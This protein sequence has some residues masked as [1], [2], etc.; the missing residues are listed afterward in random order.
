MA[1]SKNKPTDIT[2][3]GPQSFRDLQV[4]NNASQG[5][6]PAVYNALMKLAPIAGQNDLRLNSPRN[7]QSPVYN[8]E[9][10]DFLGNSQYD[11][12]YYTEDE[13]YRMRENPNEL[14][15]ENQ[16]WYDTLANGIGKM[17]GTAGTTFVSSLV[18]LPYGLFQVGS[19]G[20]W[21]AIW[22]NDVTQGLAN[23]DKWLE[24]N[25]TNYKSQKQIDSPWYDPANLFSMNF[26][27]D[28]I[29]KN[30]G[31]TLGAAASMAVGS[32]SLGLMS[33]AMGL[34]GGAGSSTKMAGN[35]LSALFSATGEGMIEARQGV[36]E[37]NKLELQRLDD[38]MLP[39]RQSLEAEFNKIQAEY[40]ANKGLSYVRGSDGKMQDAAYLNYRQRMSDLE[41]RRD[42]F[43][44]RYEAGK[45][46]IEETGLEMGNM[47]LGANQILL[48]AGN[49]IQ[50]SKIMTKSFDNARHAAENKARFH[51]P[52]GV[53]AERAGSTFREGY[54]VTGKNLGMTVAATKGLL[55]EG[56][57][58][59]NQQ[60]IQNAAGYAT[61]REDVNDYWR[62]KLDPEAT[63]DAVE[64]TYTLGQA[65][66]RGFNES[67]SDIDQ[68]EQFLI[69]GLTGLAG[70]YAPTK[71][72]NQDKTKAWYDL[73]RYGEWGGGAYNEIRDFL[74]GDESTGQM[75]Y[76]EYVNRI[77]EVNNILG[78][79]DFPARVSSL[80]GHTFLESQKTQSAD[81]ND[82]KS[83]KDA[84]DKQTIMDIQAFLRAGKL[85]DLRAIYNEMGSNLSDEDID[86]IVKSTTH[87]SSKEENKKYFDS[88]IDSRI[89][90]HQS[91]I[92]RI[93]GQLSEMAQEEEGMDAAS[94]AA[95]RERNMAQTA[96]LTRELQKEQSAIE[97][98]NDRKAMYQGHKTFDGPY[99]DLN[100]NRRKSNDEIREEIK[101]NADEL[102]RRIDS[103]LD[104]IHTVQE[105]SNGALT[106][107]QEDNL[108]YLHNVSKE[109][110]SR[111]DKIMSSV[112]KRLPNKFL[113][114]TS[115]SPE[116]LSK[117][118]A[119]SDLAFSRNDDTPEGYVEVDT[120]LM[121]DKNFG[122]FFAENVIW[123]ENIQ[124]QMT[125]EEIAEEKAAQEED[126][127]HSLEE[128]KKRRA[129][130]Q[131]KQAEKAAERVKQSE[132][133]R[134]EQQNKNVGL[135]RHA[136]VE[137]A[138]QQEGLSLA[139]ALHSEELD[140]IFSDINDALD[141]LNE[142]SEFY[143]TFIDY[144]SNPSKVEQSKAKQEKKAAEKRSKDAAD[145]TSIEEMMGM[146]DDDLMKMLSDGKK[147]K[148]NA[149]NRAQK[150]MGIKNGRKKVA[151]SL[152][153]AVASGALTDEA[154][155]DALR[156]LD[157]QINAMLQESDEDDFEDLSS[158]V[159]KMLDTETEAMD[160]VESLW[161]ESYQLGVAQGRINPEDDEESH[162][163][164]LDAAKDALN[165]VRASVEE[166]IEELDDMVKSGKYNSALFD[167]NEKS[168]AEK[169]AE[170]EEA[171]KRAADE[172]KEAENPSV[173][174][175]KH[176]SEQSAPTRSVSN[177]LPPAAPSSPQ[178]DDV[179]VG[180]VAAVTDDKKQGE[181]GNNF[182][183]RKPVWGLWHSGVSEVAKTTNEPWQ[184][185]PSD[186]SAS[187][188]QQRYDAIRKK[189]VE[190]GA[191]TMRK[192]GKV[193]KGMKVGFVIYQDVNDE[194]GDF[195]V[196][197]TDAKGNIIG[198][199]P[200]ED[201]R[202]NRERFPIPLEPLYKKLHEEWDDAS[203]AERKDG[204]RSSYSS[205]IDELLVGKVRYQEEM[206]T[207]ASL[208]N[209]SDVK[210]LFA[211]K[212]VHTEKD[213]TTSAI[214]TGQV[215]HGEQKVKGVINPLTG[216]NGQPYILIPTAEE[217]NE[218]SD[219]RYW[220]VPIVTPTFGEIDSNSIFRKVVAELLYRIKNS[221]DDTGITDA[222]AKFLLKKLFKVKN[223]H[224]NLGAHGNTKYPGIRLTLKEGERPIT[225]HKGLRDTMDIDY[226]LA[227]LKD[228]QI[229]INID[230]MNGRTD[231]NKKYLEV[232][233]VDGKPVDYNQMLAEVSM[234]SAS[235]PRTVN[236][237]FTIK[238]LVEEGDGLRVV[239]NTVKL[240]SWA[241]SSSSNS[242]AVTPR[243]EGRKTETWYVR[244][245]NNYRV[246]DSDGNP[247]TSKTHG[248][249]EA[250]EAAK[251][252]AEVFGILNGKDIS[253]P[254]SVFIGEKGYVYNPVDRVL[255]GY[256]D[257]MDDPSI[258]KRHSIALD[259]NDERQ[260]YD[261]L[262]SMLTN[263]NAE[264]G[265]MD[266]QGEE[267]TQAQSQHP[268]PKNGE[269][270]SATASNEGQPSAQPQQKGGVAA[271]GSLADGVATEPAK[272]NPVDHT[273]EVEAKIAEMEEDA[274]HWTLVKW[275]SKTKKYVEDK[276]G[277]YYR[278]D[279]D[280]TIHARVSNTISADEDVLE[281]D[282][283][284]EF[285]GGN[286]P[287]FVPAIGSGNAVDT[288][289][290]RYF[291]GAD[292]LA[293]LNLQDAEQL[294]T[295]REL[296]EAVAESIGVPN[297]SKKDAVNLILNL[298]RIKQSI[299]EDWVIN[300]TGIVASG[301]V[302]FDGK[303]MVSVAGTIDLLA[304]NPKT[305]Q[306][307]IID[308]KTHLSPLFKDGKLDVGPK[309]KRG[310]QNKAKLE[311]WIAQQTLY[312][313]FLEKKFGIKISGIRI[314]P[315]SV[316]YST[317]FSKTQY[318][319]GDDG[320][321]RD[322]GVV[323]DIHPK[324]DGTLIPLSPKENAKYK[325]ASLPE[326][327]K[328]LMPKSSAVVSEPVEAELPVKGVL[329]DLR[330]KVPEGMKLR[331]FLSDEYKDDATVQKL[332]DTLDA[333]RG[334]SEPIMMTSA[335]HNL[336]LS[337]I[338]RSALEKAVVES[339]AATEGV[340]IKV[341]VQQE[342]D[343]ESYL[344]DKDMDDV[345]HSVIQDDLPQEVQ[346]M[347]V[348]NNL[349]G[350]IK[351]M[352][353]EGASPEDIEQ[354]VRDQ[355]RLTRNKKAVPRYTKL[356]LQ[357]E[358]RWMQRVLPQLSS[359]RRLHI[360][361]GLI[362]CSDGT[363]SFGQINGSVILIGTQAAEGTVYHE[364]FHAVVQF[365]LTDDEITKLYDAAKKK[366]GN[367]PVAALEERLADDFEDHILGLEHEDSSIRR[368]FKELWR[369]IKAWV[370]DTSAIETVYR[371]IN[372]GV[373]ANTEIKD[374]RN[375]VFRY[376]TREQRSWAA[377]YECLTSDE[378]QRLAAGNVDRDTYNSLT[379]KQKKYMLHCVV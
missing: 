244:P 10:S 273:K 312:K 74:N 53:G 214:L 347:I 326:S 276:E 86:N 230:L 52:F 87:E 239:E 185:D 340:Q 218:N 85:D 254:Y 344:A 222:H 236:D 277:D 328:R 43:N 109:K 118:Y 123:G 108:A 115:Q 377:D 127:K 211:V 224:V 94:V 121:N 363:E 191:Y 168:A 193:K 164:R 119:S 32:G 352:Y 301:V 274:R 354:A 227:A 271:T 131:K 24:D 155:D 139:Q 100:G 356:D 204:M 182:P 310:R 373:Y 247:I 316:S 140:K 161:D 338:D 132:Q 82:M 81:S 148:N 285:T 198:D 282:E 97:S 165:H 349:F 187:L 29:I 31:F 329:S 317:R 180:D 293:D 20:R 323:V 306:Y 353:E 268:E 152:D 303:T 265:E 195:V 138:M 210:P 279:R 176:K 213:V 137:R 42:D 126:K 245:S 35:A 65:I 275:D 151:K 379:K 228:V 79:E 172:S 343:I 359:E 88:Q 199:L 375:N 133:D 89:A 158:V 209:G 270:E 166:Q 365:L 46:Q 188:Q 141:L 122:V 297:I 63:K 336:L 2:K 189:L 208:L 207:V 370:S 190:T 9:T 341:P 183:E 212:T 249:E 339:Q 125:A 220:A 70:S 177:P 296:A 351:G 345:L 299:G 221:S 56:S 335:A 105:M 322:G 67:W 295:A 346:Q 146:S 167:D 262:S 243:L 278:D 110:T 300:S 269:T 57:E 113:L 27:A 77:N 169:L 25:M 103:Y 288:F 54:N 116:E 238:P 216:N 309:T 194:A 246:Y 233:T 91:N 50:F 95:L 61:K 252:A 49:L 350:M 37:R 134:K 19:Q 59:M 206:Q 357:K 96:S 320:V 99:V 223:V 112:R 12:D 234:T 36:E 360:V 264:M 170:L 261:I 48:T 75:G 253:R 154:A 298:H 192:T 217:G 184:A 251:L 160:D 334:S 55:T 142:A 30:A 98:L 1:T 41:A 22:D 263:A 215:S 260:R 124:P 367:L 368:F 66:S 144:M 64:G 330:D 318:E 248:K 332:A 259:L 90:E 40:E 286:N 250:L 205:Y 376:V 371:D 290:R 104:S 291:Q 114:K 240:P 358:L 8:P 156:L 313:Q 231:S 18:G 175:P 171:V 203:D 369:I 280:G 159:A 256:K 106:K 4:Q 117:T 62:A 327:V 229:G 289:V 287:S 93:Q 255:K 26:I 178:D 237:G 342:V 7:L 6:D 162:R 284:A 272:K 305:G 378:R 196:F 315:F 58:E 135:I 69:G 219:R 78:S 319:I 201:A 45:Q 325:V 181:K 355:S 364:A 163:Q 292:P 311:H 150:A 235:E 157:S 267:R 173:P 258:K 321:L 5:V 51:L 73:R 130:R 128:Q 68:W 16:P 304:Y 147:G 372:N 308:M 11:Q 33:K 60:W 153:D 34:V 120:S 314:M 232:L 92:D 337:A 362:R 266:A 101:H 331:D 348:D 23:V 174:Q 83:W 38:E 200:S 257:V 226:I 111:F 71:I 225:I 145:A 3:S 186:P 39:E 333:N 241:A 28:D 361:K 197:I 294:K 143:N 366:W 13:L 21:S 283:A 324:Y 84:D 242:V 374:N 14:R 15:Y 307:C 44:R 17:L 202:F 136:F 47:I 80:V 281:A 179:A 302:S 107:D 149:G 129:E 76:N 72:F 102:N